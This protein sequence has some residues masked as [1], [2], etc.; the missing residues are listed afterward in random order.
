MTTGNGKAPRR[1]PGSAGPNYSPVAPQGQPVR[2]LHPIPDDG[3]CGHPF[4]VVRIMN[5]VYQAEKISVRVGPAAVLIEVGKSFLQHP[6][7][8]KADGQISD[9]AKT[10]LV[11]SVFGRVR[12]KRRACTE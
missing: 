4:I 8:V 12:Q 3:S 10:L 6:Q 11:E 2:A 1:V 7:P 5:A 9:E